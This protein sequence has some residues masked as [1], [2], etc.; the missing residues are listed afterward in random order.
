MDFSKKLE[1][2]NFNILQITM[3]LA[4]LAYD[5]T[6]ELKSELSNTSIATENNW[7]L[8]WGPVDKKSNRV[9]V[10]KKKTS[11]QYAIAIRGTIKNVESMFI[12]AN[13][14][15]LASL[16][17]NTKSNKM[18]SDGMYDAWNHIYGMIDPETGRS[19]S[20][21]IKIL[22]SDSI[23]FV[24]GHSQGACLASVVS[25][26]LS[27][28]Y[29]HIKVTPITF[30]AETAGNQTFSDLFNTTFGTNNLRV[31][32]PHDIVPM[33][34]G[35]LDKI[36]HIYGTEPPYVE[37]PNEFKLLIDGLKAILPTY[38][39]T[40]RALQLPNSFIVK[41]NGEVHFYNRPKVFFEEVGI[42]HSCFTYLYLLNAPL[43]NGAPN[44]WPPNYINV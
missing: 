23:V 37:C 10:V 19:L 42:Q 6:T 1:G 26:W 31:F 34:F 25:L 5:S 30:A 4:T 14:L 40:G 36:K 28:T 29:S 15:K 35:D 32:N 41:V 9:Y 3:T 39:Q 8:V 18:I 12:D 43:T 27:Q 7:S 13:S 38:V 21:F 44:T 11:N 2:Q 16:S 22:T 24:T 17:W 20:D 33:G